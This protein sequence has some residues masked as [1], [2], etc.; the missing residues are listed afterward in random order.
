MVDKETSGRQDG[1][2]RRRFLQATGGLAGAMAFAGC[3]GG[4][5]ATDT[6]TDE[7]DGTPTEAPEMT[8]EPT[9]EP[10]QRR[11]LR[12]INGTITTF[13]PVAA[14]DTASGRII[15]NVFDALMNYPNG[16]TNVENLLAEDFTVSDDFLTY[17]FTLKDA[18]YH[19]GQEVTAAD[20]VY[21]FKRL[22]FSENS[23]RSYFILDSL[24]VSSP[25]D[26]ELEAEAVDDKTLR[27]T[28]SQPFHSSLEMLAYTSFSAVPEGIVGDLPGYDGEMDYNEFATSNPIGAGPFEFENWTQGTEASVTRYADYHGEKAKIAGAHWQVFE[29]D[30][31]QYNYAMNKNADVFGLPTS[32]YDPGK[33][34]VERRDSQGRQ[35]GTYG[36]LRNGDT[37]NYVKYPTLNFFYVGF[38]MARVEKPVRQAFAYAMNQQL[39]V[40]QVFKSRG[41]PAYHTTPPAIFPGGAQN[42]DQHVEDAYPYGVGETQLDMARQVMEEAG[43]GPN[44][45]VEV[46][47]TQYTSDAWLEMANILRDQL[48]SAYIDMQIEQAP[49]STLLQRGRS[50][51]LSAY[52]LGW[53]ADW[54]AADNFLQLLNPPQTDTSQQGP[55]SYTNWK[56]EY[57][58]AYQQAV[59]GWE[60]VANNQAPTE[61]AAA[62]RDEGYIMIEE[63]N[64]EDVAF[65][66]VYHRADEMF[67]YD[68]VDITPPG[69]MG[70][71]RQKYNRIT[72]GERS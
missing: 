7:P 66:N 54:P 71:S 34:N 31:A 48:S 12:R 8:D 68:W 42:Y 49:F 46:N 16:E 33:V 44:N 39:M 60:L 15:Q 13:D 52:T 67:W 9:D 62:Q 58:D 19:N 56:P 61:E 20:F 29:D 1:I 45:R 51:E 53:I 22:A 59:D 64:W 43:Y 57:G 4:G 65:L 5:G 6:P 3:T 72:V 11:T 37:A 24:G 32:Q 41:A 35:I 50:G 70:S 23:R 18:T 17:E 30:S 28:L 26:G 38:N 55:I 14:T 25:A 10:Q 40:D 36:P 69:A 27:L 21:A 2:D 63:A 47:W